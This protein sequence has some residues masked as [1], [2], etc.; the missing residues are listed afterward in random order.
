MKSTISIIFVFLAIF[1]C[2]KDIV[3]FSAS[4]ED[5]SCYLL[6]I[7][8]EGSKEKSEKSDIDEDDLEEWQQSFSQ[9]LQ[10]I[11][12]SMD[13]HFYVY[14]EQRHF[15]PFLEICSPPPEQLS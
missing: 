13:T 8:K 2:T 12:I 9:R 7:S 10:A 1:F 15:K 4:A 6:D 5:T 11:E 3:I 14:K